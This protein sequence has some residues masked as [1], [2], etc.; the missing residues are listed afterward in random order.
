MLIQPN[1]PKTT[2]NYYFKRLAHPFQPFK[3]QRE[4]F[5]SIFDNDILLES[6]TSSGKTAAVVY[7]IVDFIADNQQ[8]RALFVYPTRAL[9]WDQHQA[10]SNVAS[11]ADLKAA[12]LDPF[13]PTKGLYEI[14]AQNRLIVMTPD[15][16]YYTLLRNAQHYKRFF[17][18]SVES[19]A[20]IVF[21]EVHLY[22]TYM[23]FNLRHLL[24]IIRNINPEI[25]IHCLSATLDHVK[26]HFQNILDFKAITG[27]S[28]T[29]EV[30]IR[31]IFMPTLKIN[32]DIQTLLKEPGR[33]VLI[34]NSAKRA[35]ET[36]DQLKEAFEDTFFVVG[37][38]Y[39]IEE[40][41]NQSLEQFNQSKNGILV[42]S[43]MVEQGV[44]FKANTVISE[45]PSTLFSIIQRF[46][47]VGRG[48]TAGQFIILSRT[49]Q[50]HNFY[51]QGQT[52]SRGK[53]ENL[54]EDSQGG[55][56]Y[57]PP[58]PEE[59][60]MM[61]A[62]LYK[63]YART[64]MKDSFAAVVDITTLQELYE[65][66]E[67]FLPDL[68]FREPS[69]AVELSSGNMVSVWDVVKRDAWRRLCPSNDQ[70]AVGYV[71]IEAGEFLRSEFIKYAP[72]I[73]L[74]ESKV[75]KKGQAE[76]LITGTFEIQGVTF[77]ANG[78]IGKNWVTGAYKVTTS[79]FRRHQDLYFEP[80]NFF[81]N[82]DDTDK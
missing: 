19:V 29:G 23:L 75:F 28:F 25:R 48:G 59:V 68:S 76:S 12:K 53:F 20:H 43:P 82:A 37:S 10:I 41:R 47:R 60:E 15:V 18:R 77:K 32:S 4:V 66:Y 70:V 42:A 51:N 39:Q 61:E 79:G 33:K 3:H 52:L 58:L 11:Q 9:L 35:K 21:D 80:R 49:A 6:P 2:E 22:D 64:Q 56:Y 74:K 16:F 63:L 81:E 13:T 34:L 67:D 24:K 62:M 69:P 31:S 14:F 71:P 26:Q 27:E 50:R 8:K 1:T 36:F 54:L 46:G 44:D 38:R 5:E 17:E 57:N 55:N 78:A 7:P 45:D 30:K 40:E 72:S 65:K 73:K